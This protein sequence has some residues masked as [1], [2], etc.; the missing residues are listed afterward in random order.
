[1]ITTKNY[2]MRKIILILITLIIA[3]GAIFGQDIM[4]LSGKVIDASSKRPLGFAS[5]YMNSTN[6]SNVSNMDGVF[7]LKVPTANQND[8]LMISYLGYRSVKVAVKDFRGGEEMTIAMESSVYTMDPII[9]RPQDAASFMKMAIT[10]ID[11]NYSQ[12]PMQMTAF[13]REMIRKRNTY[14]SISEAVL[15]VVKS[16]YRGYRVDQVGIYKARGNHDQNRVDTLMVKF[17]GGP[18]SALEIDVVKSPFLWTDLIDMD[19]IYDFKFETPVTIDDRFFYV[20]D[21]NQKPGLDDMYFRGKAYIDSETMAVGRM[22]FNMNVEGN[23]TKAN[24]LF[25]RKKPANLKMDI[26]SARYIVN[27]RKSEG[28]W[29]FDYSRTELVLNTRWEKKWFSS[30]SYTITSELA[31]TDVSESVE[32]RIP[33]ED[34]VRQ[35]DIISARVNDY[36]DENFWEDY[37]VIEPE[38]SIERVINRIVRQLRRRE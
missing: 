2:Q 35:S 1:M 17:Q 19:N 34:R 8:T 16:S 21:F 24:S 23:S 14:V 12:K 32:R 11:K 38:E 31:V 6:I 5:I 28:I 7:S 25:I 18:N 26:V 13:Y 36:T 27:Y 30:N 3:Q 9:V 22:E 33:S 15:D 20:I 4:T 37:N 29:L 10:N